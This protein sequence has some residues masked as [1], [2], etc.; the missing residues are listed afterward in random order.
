MIPTVHL[1][2]HVNGVESASEKGLFVDNQDIVQLSL[3]S[4]EHT[5]VLLCA[6]QQSNVGHHLK[7]ITALPTVVTTQ[8]GVLH[9]SVHKAT[10]TWRAAVE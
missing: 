1:F 9:M 2:S 3:A 4:I 6:L 8:L 5:G 7:S 10:R